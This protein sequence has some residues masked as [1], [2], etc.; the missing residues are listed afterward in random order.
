[1]ADRLTQTEIEKAL[2]DPGAVF[3]DPAD[4][5]DAQG[6]D[7]ARKIEI[8]RRWEYDARELQVA[9]EEGMQGGENHGDLLDRVN[10]ALHALGAEPGLDSSPP[11]K[12]G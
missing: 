10:R 11:T 3:G 6:L 1:M 9:E 12:Q 7:Q 2:V 8:L 4:V 5:V